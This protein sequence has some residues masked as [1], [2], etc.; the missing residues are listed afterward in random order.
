MCNDKLNFERKN[1][2]W[3]KTLYDFLEHL[4]VACQNRFEYKVITDFWI[5]PISSSQSIELLISS[6]K[7]DEN[8]VNRS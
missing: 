8:N 3:T 7:G 4:I 6:P 5:T 1:D 2:K